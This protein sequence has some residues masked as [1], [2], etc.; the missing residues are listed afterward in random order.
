LTSIEVRGTVDSRAIEQLQRCADEG[1]AVAAAICADGHVGYSQ[2]I[3]GVVA[4]RDF[5]SPSGVG[6]DI[7]CGNKAVQTNL[8][9]A[10][11]ARFI[12]DLMDEIAARISFG[13]GRANNEPVDHPV[14]DHIRDAPFVPQ[15]GLRE[16]AA[17]QLGTVG[18]GNHYVDLFADEDGCVWVGVHFGSRG[19]GH[20][21][22]SGFLA[23]A[24][25]QQFDDRAPEGEMDSPPILLS[26]DSDLGQA[27]IE[28]MTLA[29]EYA[30]AGRDVV[31]DKVLEILGAEGRHEVHNHHNFAWLEQHGN[32]NVWVV[33]KGCTP[34]FP[35]QE[36]F[37][38]ATMG[39]TSVI[40][41]GIESDAGA[42][43]LYSTVHGAGRVMSRT[44]AAGRSRK[45]WTCLSDDCDWFQ[46]PGVHVAQAEGT[47]PAELACPKCGHL[48]LAKQGQQLS[49]G[50]I[51]FDQVRANLARQNVELRGGAAD[52]A[53]DAYK[54]LDEVLA[55]HADTIQ[56][57]HRLTPVGVAMAGADVFD[58]FKD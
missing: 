32:E 43:L 50:K 20:K 36:G 51:D 3:G 29:G 27:Y 19:F 45:R 28:A 39:E 22:A 2:P 30:Y 57:K 10:E 6:Y 23:L 47:R 4:Y 46:G 56:I 5:I 53:P 58:P 41:E 54:R 15:R 48:G 1:D 35:G 17:R 55:A 18:A 14:L 12:P 8:R 21:T 52:E 16:M 7:G 49:A 9:F 11:I 31:V 37:V 44:Q 13:V 25:G 34:A 38:G 24:A 42:S 33:R 26:I 40:L